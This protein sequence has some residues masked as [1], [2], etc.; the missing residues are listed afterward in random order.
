MPAGYLGGGRGGVTDTGSKVYSITDSPSDK[1]IKSFAHIVAGVEPGVSRTGRKIIQGAEGEL[2][3]SGVPISLQD[4]MLAL[5]SGI[6]IINVDVPRSYSYKLAEYG[7]EKK[8]VTAAEDFY[9]TKDIFNRGGEI[10]ADEFRAIQDEALQIQ[11]GMAITIQDAI[12]LGESPRDL[13]KINKRR[14]SN[15][16]FGKLRRKKFTPVP[17]S[18]TLM[19]KRYD[20]V[21]KAYPNEKVDRSF[22]FPIKELRKVIREYRNKDLTMPKEKPEIEEEIIDQTSEVVTPK[23]NRLAALSKQP[24]QTP[25]LPRTPTPKVGIAGISQQKNPITGLT[26]TETALLSPS[27][28]EIARRT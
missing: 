17:Y 1:I 18:V 6:R 4:E 12:D 5:F 27:E 8:A 9:S 16:E 3:P 23:T 2:T 28:Q 22:V 10:L 7:R 14:L 24:I 15:K 19:K 13:R 25:P 26:R 20:T 11:Q 21:K